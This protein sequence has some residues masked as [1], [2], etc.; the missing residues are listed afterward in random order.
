MQRLGY[1][2]SR[3]RDCFNIVYLEGSNTNGALNSDG[4]N[5]FN[6][7]RL[8]L[9]VGQDGEP[10]TMGAWVATTEPGRY[11]TEHPR[12]PKAP[13][14]SHLVNTRRGR[15]ER[16]RITKRLFKPRPSPCFATSA[17]PTPVLSA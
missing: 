11:Y 12:I 5:K 7:V 3:H 8:V 16:I 1:W 15:W 6:D 13:R 10:K 9:S 14:E 4:P 17:S 2:I